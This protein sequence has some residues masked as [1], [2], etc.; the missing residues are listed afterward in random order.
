MSKDN[1]YP[2]F[3]DNTVRK[4]KKTSVGAVSGFRLN[5]YNPEQRISFLLQ[6]NTENY[7]NGVLVF[8]YDTDVVE[9]Y[10]DKEARLFINL[11]KSALQN[12]LLAE[13]EGTVSVDISNAMSDEDIQSI[14]ALTN[15]LQFK[16]RIK[17]I[18]SVNTLHRI[19]SALPDTRSNAHFKAI[20]EKL[21]DLK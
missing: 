17:D 4:Y 21:E 2:E 10:S 11:N 14:A 8:E 7:K 9:L 20:A 5:P 6:S 18:T 15:H 13:Y 19:L 12:G 16:K 3:S 1:I